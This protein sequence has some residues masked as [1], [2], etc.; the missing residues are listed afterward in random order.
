MSMANGDGVTWYSYGYA[1]VTVPFPEDK[2]CCRYC[3]YMR[4]DAGGV[5]QKCCLTG[6]VL[7]RLDMRGA[8]CPVVISKEGNTDE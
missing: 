1:T 7:Y 5:R 8:H 3:P 6:D 2:V 4:S